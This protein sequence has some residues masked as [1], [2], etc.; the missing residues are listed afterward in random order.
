MLEAAMTPSILSG[1][2]QAP[3]GATLKTPA[4]LIPKVDNVP[5]IGHSGA[6]CA[7]E[8][9]TDAGAART[10]AKPIAFDTRVKNPSLSL[11]TVRASRF[12]ERHVD[13]DQIGLRPKSD[14]DALTHADVDF[15]RDAGPATTLTQING[16]HA[17]FI[18][19][20]DLAIAKQPSD[21]RNR[22]PLIMEISL[23]R[24]S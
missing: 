13:L 21:L 9:D 24:A 18:R 11:S 19:S 2:R 4:E 8:T 16:P 5:A 23:A 12:S 7:N 22:Q 14:L 3:P 6:F 17:L 15:R 20:F 10:A 1:N